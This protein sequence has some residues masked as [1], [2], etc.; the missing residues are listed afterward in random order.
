MNIQGETSQEHVKLM[1]HGPE[2]HQFAP[3]G[4]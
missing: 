3:V 2:M 1:V 4:H